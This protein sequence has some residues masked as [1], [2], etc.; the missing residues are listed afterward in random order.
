MGMGRSYAKSALI[1]I[2]VVGGT[3]VFLSLSSCSPAVTSSSNSA[4]SSSDSSLFSSSSSSASVRS[5]E[6][7]SSEIIE[8]YR[9]IFDFSYDN[10]TE[11]ITVKCGQRIEKPSEPTRIGY[12]FVN[13]I[14]EEGKPFDFEHVAIAGDLT[15]YAQWEHALYEVRFLNDDGSLLYTQKG[16]YGEDVLYLGDEPT[17]SNIPEGHGYTFLGW[18]GGDA[19]EGNMI[20]TACYDFFPL[21][22]IAYFYDYDGQTV[23]YQTPISAGVTP[24]FEGEEPTRPDDEENGFGFL[25]EG[26]QALEDGIS[27]IAVYAAYSLGLQIQEG[28]VLSY[29]GQAEEIIIPDIWE[30]FDVTAI[31]E[32]VFMD[33]TSIRLVQFPKGLTSIGRAAFYGCIHL[34]TVMLPEGVAVL[35][36]SVFAMCDWLLGILLPH[37]LTRIETGSFSNDYSMVSIFYA[38]S[39]E[40]WDNV[41]LAA[42]PGYGYYWSTLYFYS[43]SPRYDGNY[44]WYEDGRIVSH[45][46]SN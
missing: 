37:S 24:T 18:N 16:Y 35:E 41:E 23:L 12:V 31:A 1:M 39:Q 3:L 29:V 7:S 21:E 45:K 25:F 5:L 28:T 27:F 6:T 17:P 14:D 32:E 34:E 40:D 4:S 13:W 33:C 30:G 44:W 38:G 22:T 20:L 10:L 42:D 8:F 2:S 9:V 43:E 26:W 19:I 36:E 15:L 46:E 11:E